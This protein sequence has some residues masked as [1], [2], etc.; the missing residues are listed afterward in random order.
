M[1]I[2]KYVQGNKAFLNAINGNSKNV[3]YELYI[4]RVSV[5]VV[6]CDNAIFVKNFG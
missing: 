2:M 4:I 1:I 3:K 6:F 5:L